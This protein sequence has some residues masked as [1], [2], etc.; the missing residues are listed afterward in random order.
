MSPKEHWLL[1]LV[2]ILNTGCSQSQFIVDLKAKKDTLNAGKELSLNLWPFISKLPK[3]IKSVKQNIPESMEYAKKFFTQLSDDEGFYQGLYKKQCIL[4]GID[5]NELEE[6]TPHKNT[7]N[8]CHLMSK[9]CKDSDFKIGILAIVT[10][11]LAATVFARHSIDHFETFF[12]ENPDQAIAIDEGLEWLRLHAKPQPR[13]AIWMRRAVDSLE[14][15]V[16]PPNK[17]PEEVETLV[18]AIFDFWHCSE[19]IRFK[20]LS[21]SKKL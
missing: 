2:E 18:E 21:L 10:A 1:S 15:D 20:E 3:N 8:L 19:K 11:E 17:Y 5:L 13:H 14:L 9:Y 6:L 12:S 4:A 16:N 7:E